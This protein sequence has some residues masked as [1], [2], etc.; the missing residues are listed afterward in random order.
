[1]KRILITGGCGFIG[2]HTAL[3][4]LKKEYELVII[5]SLVNSFPIVIEK[6]KILLKKSHPNVDKQI[7]LKICDLCDFHLLKSIFQEFNTENPIS[8]VIHFAGLKAVSESI[9]LPLK[10]WD[11]NVSGTIN[12]LKIMDEFNCRNLVFSSSATIYGVNDKKQNLKEDDLKNPLNTYGETKYTI[13]KILNSLIQSNK[14]DW[15]LATLRYF[16]PIGAHFSGIIGESPRNYPT[17]IM[18]IITSVALRKREFLSIY[19]DNYNTPDG[20][21]IRDYI[22]VED[23]AEGH[24]KALEYL[25]QGKSKQLTL[26]LGTGKGNSVL[27]LIH[28]FEEVNNISIPYKFSSRRSGDIEYSVADNL[29]AKTLLN[30]E[31]IKDIKDMCKDSW[32]WVYKNPNGFL[33]M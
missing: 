17:N 32:N 22:H 16:N 21:P 12:L 28:V 18:P 20:T 6:I 8:A 4:L 1:M 5:D 14:K 19:G 7:H 11:S 25:I 3:A 33:N 27:E 9:S 23:L 29:Q 24:I 13:E 15:R 26:N 2:S 30:W 31:P 10:Y